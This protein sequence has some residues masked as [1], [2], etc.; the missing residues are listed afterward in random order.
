MLSLW[1]FWLRHNNLLFLSCTKTRS[2]GCLNIHN[3]WNLTWRN[4][5]LSNLWS[6]RSSHSWSSYSS[7]TW[8]ASRFLNYFLLLDFRRFDIRNYRWFDYCCWNL[9]S[10]SFLNAR[11]R[12]N[13]CLK[14]RCRCVWLWRLDFRYRLEHFRLCNLIRDSFYN[15]C[16]NYFLSNFFSFFF[17]ESF[18]FAQ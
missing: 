13:R 3:S 9:S 17:L 11:R 6:F 1:L 5:F 12:I 8:N 7:N 4:H 10:F 2:S 16:Y 18:S 14:W 15:R